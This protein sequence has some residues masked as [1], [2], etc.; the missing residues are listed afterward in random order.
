[1]TQINKYLICACF[2]VLVFTA[3]RP[4]AG[5]VPEE[6]RIHLSQDAFN[7]SSDEQVITVSSDKRFD[8]SAIYF[9]DVTVSVSYSGID[10]DT[11]LTLYDTIKAEWLTIDYDE[12]NLLLHILVEN[13]DTGVK[14]NARI[15]TYL[16]DTGAAISITQNAN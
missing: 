9:D 5:R 10:P 13:N 4:P 12:T 7:L 1:M 3:C 16:C 14:R 2:F 8:I 15:Q 11:H 6:D